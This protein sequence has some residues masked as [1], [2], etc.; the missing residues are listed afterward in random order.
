MVT[1]SER[2]KIEEAYYKWLEK[3]SKKLG[4]GKTVQDTPTTF[5]GFLLINNMLDETSV[6]IYLSLTSLN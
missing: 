6:K 4:A 3:E 2:L 5:L 1:F